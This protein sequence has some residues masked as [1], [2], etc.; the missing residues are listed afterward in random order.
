MLNRYPAQGD[1][2]KK[3]I[4]TLRHIFTTEGPRALFSGFIPRTLWIGLGGFV[5]LGTFEAGLQ[6][7]EGG[8]SAL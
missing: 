3:I 8:R 2:N 6:V 4:A 1:V 7:L 5:F